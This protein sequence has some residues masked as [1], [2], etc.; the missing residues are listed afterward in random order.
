MARKAGSLT[1]ASDY[2]RYCPWTAGPCHTTAIWRC[3]KPF[4]QWQ[5][6]FQR[7]LRSHWLKFLRQRHVAVLRQ[8]PCLPR[9]VP[10]SWNRAYFPRTGLILWCYN[11]SITISPLFTIAWT[12]V[13]F[14]GSYGHIPKCYVVSVKK[15]PRMGGLIT[16]HFLMI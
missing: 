12:H 5:R 4:S 3:R 15:K 8:G 1:S 6:S 13:I 14:E 7:K 11:T 9:Y 2:R 16:R 10:G